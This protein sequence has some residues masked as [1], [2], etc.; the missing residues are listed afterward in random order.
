[1][2]I[3]IPMAG[4]GKRMRPHTLTVPKPLIPI[5]GKPIVQRLVEDISEVCTEKIDE[6]AYVT[7]DFGKEAEDALKGIA[8]SLGAKPKI[9][10]QHEALGTAHAIYCAE[11]SL[12]GKVIVAFADTLF[13]ASFKL[14]EQCDAIIWAHRVENPSS[15]GVLKVN[16]EN[17][18][19]DFI[20]KPEHFVSNLAIIGIYYFK[21]GGILKNELKYLLDNHIVVNGEFQ[22]TD[23]LQNMKNKKMKMIP[24]EVEE[25]LDCGNKD[26][27]VYA[28][29]RILEKLAGMQA[30]R[31]SEK[32][33]SDSAVL[34]NS[35]IIPPCFVGENVK[36]ENSIIGPHVSVGYN[37]VVKNSLIKNSIVMR[38][39]LLEN[40]NI[41]N[42]MI[43][44]YV[45]FKG[46]ISEVNIGDYAA[47]TK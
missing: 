28:N 36:I 1:M 6:I 4:I 39:S 41:S 31:Q 3:I 8:E 22:L 46:G 16:P 47:I 19:T 40:L 10:Y 45:D 29:Q 37:T 23:A 35:I 33:I 38:N 24:G 26:N 17:S 30:G 12:T 42:S 15:F 13:R 11:K 25:W 20:E 9:Y 44:N 27:T 2:K 34:V 7:G 14:D 21:D 43:G 5:A 18:I 32:L